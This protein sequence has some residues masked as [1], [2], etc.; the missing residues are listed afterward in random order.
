MTPIRYASEQ[1]KITGPCLRMR[2]MPSARLSIILVAHKARTAMFTFELLETFEGPSHHFL[3]IVLIL[4]L[5]GF[6]KTQIYC[7]IS[8]W[9]RP[10]SSTSNKITIFDAPCTQCVRG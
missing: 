6:I 3:E 5:E 8:G 4:L 9:S 1:W 10:Q 7:S 2:H